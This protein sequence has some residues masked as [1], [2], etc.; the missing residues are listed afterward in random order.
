MHLKKLIPNNNFLEED[1]LP[2][3]MIDMREINYL[4]NFDWLINFY[5]I[6]IWIELINKEKINQFVL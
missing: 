4:E 5:I 2:R 6:L 3:A 1:S